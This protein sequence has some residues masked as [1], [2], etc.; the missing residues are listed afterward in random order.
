MQTRLECL[1]ISAFCM[2]I[3]A[4][5]FSYIK[6]GARASRGEQ[7]MLVTMGIGF[8]IGAVN[9]IYSAPEWKVIFYTLGAM[10]SYTAMVFSN[11]KEGD[12]KEPGISI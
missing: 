10:L 1:M 4:R 5:L 11:M 3:A 8:V 12:G 2:A 6:Q 7:L 9:A